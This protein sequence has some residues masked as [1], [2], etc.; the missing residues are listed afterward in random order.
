MKILLI[1]AAV[2]VLCLVLAAG[3][4]IALVGA[5]LKARPCSACIAAGSM[6]DE[7]IEDELNRMGW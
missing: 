1:A 4:G 2:W 5:W 7:C 6:C 3:G